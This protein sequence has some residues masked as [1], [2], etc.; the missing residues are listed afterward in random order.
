[1]KARARLAAALSVLTVLAMAGTVH[2]QFAA[3]TCVPPNCNPEVIQNIAIT[4]T[5]QTASINV[6]GSAK[7]GGTFQTGALAPVQT[8]ATDNLYYGNVG[9]T[10]TNG[11]QMLLQ[12]GSADRFRVTLTGQQ[13]L[14]LGSLTAPSYS[15][16]GDTN[17]GFYSS[18][19]DSFSFVT[20]GVARTTINNSGTT[21][22]SG[23]LS[24]PAGTNAAPSLT[25][26]GDTNTGIFRGTA[27]TLS[28]VTNGVTGMTVSATNNVVI[29]GA[30][31]VNGTFSS[32]SLSGNGSAITNLNAS[33][34]TSGT[35]ADARLSTNV[36][37][38]NGTQT[39]T[40]ANTFSNASNSFTGSGAGLTSLNATNI[41]SGTLADAR[42][43]S[44]VALYNANGTFT[45]NN[46]F[47]GMTSYGSAVLVAGAGQNLIYGVAD[48]TS[49]GNLMLLQSENAGVYTDR[50]RVSITGVVT[51][52]SFSGVGTSLTAL[53]ATN[54]T[55]GTVP[56]ARISGTYSNNLT[57]SG[58]TAFGSAATVVAAGQNL[59][60]GNVDTTSGGNLL[61]LQNESADRFRVDAAGNL[62]LSGTITA[63][64]SLT[65]GGVSVCLQNGTNCPATLSGG[66]TPN[67]ITKFTGTGNTVG[68]SALY[69]DG[70]GNIGLGTASPSAKLTVNGSMS[71][72]NISTYMVAA[73]AAGITGQV[74]GVGSYG[75]VGSG[76][77][78]GVYGT[79]GT[80]GVYGNNSSAGGTGAGVYGYHGGTGP[81]VQGVSASGWGG[82][83][84][85]LYV[86]PG[87]AYF[88]SGATIGPGSALNLGTG[89]SDP[90]GTN[91]AIFYNTT[92][93]TFRCY[94]SGAWG[95]CSA[96]VTGTGTTNYLPKFTSAT[97]IGNSL[98]YDNGTNVGIG[99]NS[100][101]ASLQV[102]GSGSYGIYVSGTPSWGVYSATPIEANGTTFAMQ[103]T[104]GGGAGAVHGT[105]TGAGIV[106]GVV[107]NTTVTTDVNSAGVY[108]SGQN[109][110]TGYS[111]IAGG[112]GMKAQAFTAATTGIT[113]SVSTTSG[114]AN[115]S[116]IMASN[117]STVAVTNWGINAG[118]SGA[119]GGT[120]IGAYLNASNG[121]NNYALIT[122]LGK[123][124]LGEQTP[125][126]A[127]V[128]GNDGSA[129]LPALA[130][131]AGDDSDTGFFH[132]NADTVAISAGGT[133]RMRVNATGVG[134]GTTPTYPFD[135]L[136]SSAY[137][138]HF[139]TNSGGVQVYNGYGQTAIYANSGVGNATDNIGLLT[140]VSGST[141][142]NYGVYSSAGGVNAYSFYGQAGDAYFAGNVGIG[143]TT[144]SYPL[145]VNG[146]AFFNGEIAVGG[147]ISSVW[148]G[149]GIASSGT[150][151]GGHFY[152]TN[153]PS[154]YTAAA[155]VSGSTHYGTFGDSRDS[156]GA[157]TNY[158]GYFRA[159]YG[160]TNYGVYAEG[161]TYGVYGNGSSYGLY[162]NGSS[163]GVY[164]NA[165]SYGVRGNGSYG[166]Y[167]S[168]SSYG[169]YFYNTTYGVSTYLAGG[170]YGV[171]VGGSPTYGVYAYGNSTAGRFYDYDGTA[172][173]FIAG[174]S[175]GVQIVTG[176]AIKPSGSSWQV[177]SDKRVKKDVS[178]FADGLE[179]LRKLNPVNFTYNGLGETVDGLKGI[180]FIAQD[181]K[182]I[183]PYMMH[184]RKAKLHP[185]DVEETDI[186]TIEDSALSYINLNAIKT[187]D[188]RIEGMTAK[189]EKIDELDAKLQRLESRVQEL[190]AEVDALKR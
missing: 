153:Y 120:N 66:G 114:A 154:T 138:G 23:V 172:T 176:D 145:D 112:S 28:F 146:Q 133:E 168:G 144:P 15:F 179:T 10:S 47:T 80:Y 42:L 63:T 22:N 24:L 34:I 113:A 86:T 61:L 180:G 118:A 89:A 109:G 140:I 79:A 143:N 159:L 162:G 76:G 82:S 6:S 127:V 121:A 110:V 21:V 44:N 49:A 99:T 165:S 90:T 124:D 129:A 69:D 55:S 107:G 173:T 157:G 65:S 141:S 164:G 184:T 87:T 177:S 39:F 155:F 17:T 26:T 93:N 94:A 3:P 96:G 126:N 12:F 123:V 151:A 19:A 166:I 136:S 43:S 139:S 156:N 41:T 9:G 46:S 97:S 169:G 58:Q 167:G 60:Y 2:A 52:N 149:Y 74:V 148:T 84:S 45:G 68:D 77:S 95:P 147:D 72:L 189:I 170:T 5:A 85:S 38:L 30:L 35:L 70:G 54:L 106:Y 13:Q 27:D 132:P 88:A 181:V 16:I 98:I 31:T 102:V 185:D 187:L 100:P 51:A 158:G 62:T 81:G 128:V 57:F 36:P 186:Y 134:I 119:N 33:N 37:L 130:I 117:N 91:G 64:G 1:M 78:Y 11:A 142:H 183:V 92:S 4:G 108:G 171:Y 175:Y 50:F 111:N 125:L 59:L 40:G 53:N 71:A 174:A 8:A 131:G 105:A 137:A 14:P 29:P 56:S 103:G 160:G 122:Y 190:E 83:F 67:Y 48:S 135:V 32:G 101:G 150:Q 152:N 188:L 116:A 73:G 20:N 182:D 115:T 7:L 75:V 25:F 178:G 161:N 18:G 104:A 163:Y